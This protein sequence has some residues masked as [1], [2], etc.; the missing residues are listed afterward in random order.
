MDKPSQTAEGVALARAIAVHEKDEW[1][2][3]PDHLAVHLLSPRARAIARTP[4]LRALAKAA[5][6]R[7]LPGVYMF[8]CVR[9]RHFDDVFAARIA[10][11]VRQLVI[12]GAGLD[13]RAYRFSQRLRGARVFEVDHP[14]TAACKQQRVRETLPSLPDNVTYV[15]VDFE[16]D[17]LSENLV[18]AGLD[19]ARP[20]F[21]LMEGVTMYLTAGALDRTLSCITMTA[22]GSTVAFEYL[23]AD[24]H[25][26]PE[27]YHGATKMFRYVAARGEPY[28]SGIDPDRLDDFLAARGMR[29]LSHVRAEELDRMYRE[30]PGWRPR[31][32]MIDCW[33]AVHA[34][35]VTRF[36]PAL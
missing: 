6:A 12:L 32:R 34:E 36:R 24:A 25:Q 28:R 8:H 7:I 23:Y 1:L 13:T 21:Y 20:T 5:Y 18:A 22:P 2:R 26:R 15:A 9:T 11:G 3:G 31:H 4:V 16:N 17:S 33:G 14:R 27:R 19:L 35:V 29:A 10:A 30:R